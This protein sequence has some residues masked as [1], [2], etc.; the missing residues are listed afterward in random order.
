[1]TEI[2]TSNK[3]IKKFKNGASK[4]NYYFKNC[5]SLKMSQTLRKVTRMFCLTEFGGF[6]SVTGKIEI[7]I[8][9]N[10]EGEVNRSEGFPVECPLFH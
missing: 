10:H 1:M 5:L 4:N 7:D 2:F 9:I 3:I 6:G 8:K